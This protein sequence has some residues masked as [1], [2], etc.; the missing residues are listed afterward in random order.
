MKRKIAMLLALVIA[1]LA[2]SCGGKTGTNEQ[3]TG[4]D[5]QTEPVE[6][7]AAGPI[8]S[9]LPDADL[10]GFTLRV[11]T[12]QDKN[13]EYFTV[14]EADGDVV[15][16][17]IYDAVSRVKDKYNAS[18]EPVFYAASYNDV[19]NYVATTI[20]AGDDAYDLVQGHDCTMWQLSLEGMFADIRKLEYQ[21]FTKPWWPEYSNDTYEVNGK[22]YIF[23][24][25]MSYQSLAWAKV[26][27]MNKTIADDYKLEIPYDSVRDGSWTLDK[28]ISMTK[29]VY[30]DL[31]SDGTRSDGDLYGFLGYKKLYGWQSAFVSCYTEGSDGTISL[32]YNKEKFVDVVER[33]NSL[34]N[35]SEGGYITGN[36]PDHKIFVDGRAL[37]HYTGLETLTYDDMRASD[38]DYGVLPL[39]KYDE[40]QE[41]Y[42]TPSFDCQFAIP[43]TANELDKI[44]L[45]VEAYS[46]AGYN[47][48][49][50]A[51]FETALSTKYTRDDD[52]VEMLGIISDTLAVDLAY[53]NTS[54]GINGLGRAFMYCFLNPDAGIASYLDS[55]EPAEEAII[56]KLNTFFTE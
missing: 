54:A 12:W 39:P 2:S 4:G 41:N 31:D 35:G 1:L 50:E 52:S 16:D 15:N 44:S 25:Y 20:Q 48:T 13:G 49:R 11:A 42:I 30:S 28:F 18:I 26:L 33:M 27:F 32:G 6:T 23:S 46:S 9:Y 43:T 17:A 34:L 5:S 29:D 53:L 40:K 22:Q 47:I 38:I 51:Y 45:L 36:E 7:T 21:D 55:I 56:E 37:F 3:T 10:E 24:S 19:R 8:A 14:A